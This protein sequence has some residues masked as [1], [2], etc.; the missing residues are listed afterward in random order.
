MRNTIGIAVL[1]F[2]LILGIAG[3]G[4]HIIYSP[5]LDASDFCYGYAICQ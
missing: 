1:A 3:A 5:P 4:A 2:M